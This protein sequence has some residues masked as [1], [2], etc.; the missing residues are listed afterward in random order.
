MFRKYM[1]IER[2]GQ[3]EVDG[4][5]I[6]KVIVQPKI[7]GSNCQ[8][9]NEA[10]IH[11]GSRNQ[12][13]VGDNDHMGF[14]DWVQQNDDLLISWFAEHPAWRLYGEWLVRHTLKTY[15]ESAW[16]RFYVFDVFDDESEQFVPYEQYQPELDRLGFDYIPVM[17]TATNPTEEVLRRFVEQNTF[18]IDEGKG[19]GEG[20]VIKRYDFVNR[21]GRV[22]WGKLVRN[23]FKEKHLVAMGA[24]EVNLVPVE[25]VFV[26]T[27]VTR[28]RVEKEIARIE[29]WERRRIPELFGRVYYDIVTTELWDFIKGRKYKVT[30]DFNAMYQHTVGQIKAVY[31]EL[32]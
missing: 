31:P 12:E 8:V 7:D 2:V 32:F 26:E 23:D 3:D 20:I 6:G 5:L 4:L 15:R 17:A 16:R 24:P 22:V 27:Y 21:F 28:A 9:W 25:S 11:I 30:I 18:L 1:H 13:I 29:G 14:V 19:A 10:G